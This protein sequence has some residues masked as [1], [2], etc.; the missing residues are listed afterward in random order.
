MINAVW[1]IS[2]NVCMPMIRIEIGIENC[3]THALGVFIT[4]LKH[5]TDFDPFLKPVLSW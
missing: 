2:S 4:E 5:V 1:E 3:G